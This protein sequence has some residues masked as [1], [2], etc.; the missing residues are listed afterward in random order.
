MHGRVSS[1]C[2]VDAPPAAPTSHYGKPQTA[3]SRCAEFKFVLWALPSS[4]L[5]RVAIGTYSSLNV[6]PLYKR[7]L[8]L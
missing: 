5:L 4:V 2:R 8:L 1:Q 3:A 7:E 6:T